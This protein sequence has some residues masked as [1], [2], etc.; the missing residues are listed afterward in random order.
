MTDQEL[1]AFNAK[2]FI[3]GPNETEEQFLKRIEITRQSYVRESL[4]RAHLEWTKHH[5]SQLFGFEP[6][7]LIAFYSNENLTPWQG[8]ACWIDEKGVST[9]QLR[10]GFQKGR[11]LRLYSREEI[12]S[13]EAIHAAR[14]AFHEPEN[15]EFFAYSSSEKKWRR[16]LGPIIKRPWEVWG[17]LGSLLLALFFDWGVHLALFWICT[18]FSRLTIQHLRRFRACKNLKKQGQDNTKIRAI[19]FRLTDQEI[20]QLAKGETLK[21]DDTLRWRLLHL[22]AARSQQSP[23]DLFQEKVKTLFLP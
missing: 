19:L 6:E 11:Y 17:F 21:S 7:S 14:S 2:G 15:E 18:G 12:L 10:K 4:P 9:L 22:I 8:A 3:P 16:V 5:L 13:H 23:H 20:R 1:L